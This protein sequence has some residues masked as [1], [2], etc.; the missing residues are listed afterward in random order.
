MDFP[1]IMDTGAKLLFEIVEPKVRVV[2]GAPQIIQHMARPLF[3]R[4]HS[5][6]RLGYLSGQEQNCMKARC[7]HNIWICYNPT[8]SLCHW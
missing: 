5:F 1:D 7:I 8:T 2:Y 6:P 3:L 4:Q